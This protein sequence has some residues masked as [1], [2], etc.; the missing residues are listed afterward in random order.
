MICC[1]RWSGIVCFAICGVFRSEY[2]TDL[3]SNWKFR[4]QHDTDFYVCYRRSIFLVDAWICAGLIA[5]ES[6]GR[7]NWLW[8]RQIYFKQDAG[9]EEKAITV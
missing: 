9:S 6:G 2:D 1:C 5:Y 7:G 8:L 3:A 4:L